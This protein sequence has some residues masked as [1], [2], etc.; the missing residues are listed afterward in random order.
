[1]N[2]TLKFLARASVL[3]LVSLASA[4]DPTTEADNTARNVRD[5]DGKALT[6]PDQGS[7][8]SDVEITRKIRQEIMAK[9]GLSVNAQNVKIITN[10]GHVTLR[11]PVKTA[12][13]KE[14]IGLTAMK[15]TAKGNVDNQLEVK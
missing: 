15:H 8:T 11:G 9:D 3:V 6:P 13:E 4:A 1:M 10:N 2:S 12:E 5:R 14:F 7:S